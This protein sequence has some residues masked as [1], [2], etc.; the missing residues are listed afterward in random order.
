MKKAEDDR[1]S[2]PR[3]LVE[4]ESTGAKEACCTAAAAKQA[5]Q[6]VEFS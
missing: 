6:P 1:F 4:L 5:N 2:I 3:W